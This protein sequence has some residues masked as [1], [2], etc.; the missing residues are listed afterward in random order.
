M[1]EALERLA[2]T[3]EALR[4][5]LADVMRR[6][7]ENGEIP[8]SLGDADQAMRDAGQALGNGR[9]DQAT[10]PQGRALEGLRDGAQEALDQLGGQAQALNQGDRRGQG[11]VNRP[12]GE[13]PF[14][15]RYGDGRA[16]SDEQTGIPGEAAVKRAREILRQL[17]ERS[18]DPSRSYQER[19]Y[20]ERL[21]DR[22]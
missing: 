6:L 21:L 15:R 4:R 12:E 10:D 7:G 16:Q 17:R 9:A 20:L 22:F 11:Q 13:D 3:Q 2:Q 1:E 8:Q 14:G 18:S 5:A 19:D